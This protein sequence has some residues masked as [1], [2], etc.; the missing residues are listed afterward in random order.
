[1]RALIHSAALQSGRDG[2][3][4]GRCKVLAHESMSGLRKINWDE[5]G[6]RGRVFLKRN[7]SLQEIG[8]KLAVWVSRLQHWAPANDESRVCLP[9]HELMPVM[10]Q[11]LEAVTEMSR[12]EYPLVGGERMNIINEKE[13]ISSLRP[14]KYESSSDSLK[15]PVVGGSARTAVHESAKLAAATGLQWPFH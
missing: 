8:T 9:K 13:R 11:L 14:T 7:G 10:L 2:P 12:I 6:W 15:F 3:Q 4:I 1:M 5:D